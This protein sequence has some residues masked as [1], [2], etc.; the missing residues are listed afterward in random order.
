M[1]V[2]PAIDFEPPFEFNTD[3][4]IGRY[5]WPESAKSSD[6]ELVRT[7]TALSG[8]CSEAPDDCKVLYAIKR[9]RYFNRR[10]FYFTR[11]FRRLAFRI[12]RFRSLNL[13]SY[14]SNRTPVDEKKETC[15]TPMSHSKTVSTKALVS[16]TPHAVD[17]EP[18]PINARADVLSDS[19]ANEFPTHRQIRAISRRRHRIFFHIRQLSIACF[20]PLLVIL[21]PR[22]LFYGM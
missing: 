8:K 19:C 7:S 16:S 18:I 13:H 20:L 11:P 4:F 10:D 2:L 3:N 14:A 12:G 22:I 1:P 6:D 15:A 21:I 17:D 5:N 9:E